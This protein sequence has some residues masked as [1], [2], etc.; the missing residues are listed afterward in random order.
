MSLELLESHNIYVRPGHSPDVGVIKEWSVTYKR[1]AHA[2]K[3]HRVLDIG[4]NIGM[5]SRFALANHGA[6]FCTAYEPHPPTADVCKAN[7]LEFKRKSK[8]HVAGVEEKG[9]MAILSVPKSGNSVCASTS[10]TKRGR[11]NI[12]VPVR[13]FDEAVEDSAAT[14]VK[15]DC[16]GAELRFLNGK[17]MPSSVRVVCGELHREGG[18]EARAQAVL[19]SFAKWR[20]IHAPSSYSFHRCWI[21]AFERGD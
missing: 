11:L 13:A 6:S 5:F 21:F 19:D 7:L 9:G 8:V 16:E 4:A 18:N 15:T 20:P 14:L 10:F 2:I 3:G 12:D 17:R 1:M